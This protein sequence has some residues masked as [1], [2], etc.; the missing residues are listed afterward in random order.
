MVQVIGEISNKAAAHRKFVQAFV[1]AEQP[2]GYFVL[3]DIFRYILE[4]ED[5]EVENGQDAS[6]EAAPPLP[7]EPEPA[8]LTSSNDPSQQ[9]NDAKQIDK[10]LEEEMIQKASSGNDAVADTTPANGY[11]GNDAVE[12]NQAEDAPAAAVKETEE[13]GEAPEQ[14]A[15][16]ITQEDERIQPEEPRDPEPT[17]V[18]SPVKAS[19]VAPAENAA[20]SAT[21]R[22]TAPK[23]W[24]NLVASNRVAAPAIPTSAPSTSAATTSA[25]QNKAAPPFTNHSDTP[26]ATARETSPVKGQ[27]NGNAGWQMAGSDSNKKQGRQHG[28]SPSVSGNQ[29]V[30]L[31]YV[32][33]VTD[34]VDASILKSTLSQYGKLLYFDVS[35]PKVRLS[36]TSRTLLQ[37]SLI[38]TPELCVRGIRGFSRL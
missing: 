36:S 14:A 30:F 37:L 32:K 26:P 11:T 23:T 16:S 10:K 18:A 7:T 21:P 19:K 28:S 27:Q 33:N 4:D 22:P 38:S 12:I 20:P 3:N 9:E 15:E 25:P 35:R 24:A 13:V 1:L 17:P 29:E 6:T 2:K 31:G 5:E 8:T 34:K